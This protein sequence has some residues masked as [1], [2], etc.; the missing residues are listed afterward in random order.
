MPR[1]AC[2]GYRRGGAITKMANL[3]TPHTSLLSARHLHRR[4]NE[5]RRTPYRVSTTP[6]RGPHVLPAP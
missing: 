5:Q 2:T 1:G 6:E 4:Q 3:L